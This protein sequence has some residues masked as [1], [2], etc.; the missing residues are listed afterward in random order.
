MVDLHC[1]TRASDGQYS[2]S[3]LVKQALDLK[4]KAIAITDHDT[5]LAWDEAEKAANNQIDI[6]KGIELCISF[7]TGEFHLLALMLNHTVALDNL[8]AKAQ[9]ARLSRNLSMIEK[10]N[11][12]LCPCDYQ[13]IWNMILASNKA[14][15]T[16]IT[17]PHIAQ[18][19][20][21][22]KLASNAKEAFSRYL[23]PDKLCYVKNEGVPLLDA[24]EAIKASN[25][26]P[27][28]AHPMSLH[29]SWGHLDDLFMQWANMGISAIEAWHSGA[30]VKD[31]LRLE[32]MAKKHGFFC[33][34]GSDYHGESVKP[35]RH[36]GHTADNRI[37]EDE[38]Y[39]NLLSHCN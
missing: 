1:H 18:F 16:N 15:P 39:Y 4:M 12:L 21:E 5:I 30:K 22:K 28:I 27:A 31:C 20:V 34:A 36:L 19:L 14:K 29:V 7:Y 11:K 9:E 32:S 17:R 23:A 13:S 35:N 6:V 38:F 33:T 24:V 26:I 8:L 37:I 25:G 10:I 2:A 3:E